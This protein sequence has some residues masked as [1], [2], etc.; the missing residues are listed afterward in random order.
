ML[1]T[2]M[3]SRSNSPDGSQMKQPRKWRRNFSVGVSPPRSERI[4]FW[5]WNWRSIRSR[6]PGIHEVPPSESA[7]FRFAY[8]TSDLHQRKFAA[9]ASEFQHGSVLATSSGV[10]ASFGIVM[11]PDAM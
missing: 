10:F 1:S 5:S 6:K 11:L 8:F 7:I 9:H 3:R 2:P 4:H